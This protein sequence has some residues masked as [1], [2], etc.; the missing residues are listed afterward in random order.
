MHPLPQKFSMSPSQKVL[1]EQLI[2]EGGPW[3]HDPSKYDP[4][5]ED[6]EMTRREAEEEGH[7]PCPSCFPDTEY[8][9]NYEVKHF[10]TSSGS[11][12]TATRFVGKPED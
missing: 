4:F 8:S 11:V 6:V 10:V 3:F 5:P 9:K 7:D 1:V 2:Q 12:I